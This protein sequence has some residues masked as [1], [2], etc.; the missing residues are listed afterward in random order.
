VGHGRRRARTGST[1]T[2]IYPHADIYFHA[3]A[4]TNAHN[5]SYAHPHRHPHAIADTDHRT[6]LYSFTNVCAWSV[7][8]LGPMG[9]YGDHIPGW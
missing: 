2:D 6:Y 8:A 9:G 5:N 4:H 3:H 7:K 1:H